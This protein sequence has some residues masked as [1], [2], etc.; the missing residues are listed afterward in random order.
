[1]MKKEAGFSLVE[2]IITTAIAGL[3]FCVLGVA[4]HQVLTIPER[5][6]DHLT[7]AH[8]LQNA[9]HW[10]NLDG[11]SA[12]SATGG[13][14]LVLTLTDNS[15]ITYSL[16]G[17]NLRRAAAN[18]TMTLAQNIAALDFSI[19]DRYITTNIT[20]SPDDRWHVSKSQTYITYLR[21]SED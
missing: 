9:A 11:Q 15:T 5:G 16:V 3:I 7:A 10:L 18:S 14:T 19:Q 21:T 2:I 1:M 17:T 12:K 6:G 8:E 13:S 4:M 20:S